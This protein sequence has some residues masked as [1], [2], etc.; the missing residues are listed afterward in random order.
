M[1]AHQRRQRIVFWRGSFPVI[2][3][4]VALVLALMLADRVAPVTPQE[5]DSENLT[6]PEAHSPELGH[7]AAAQILTVSQ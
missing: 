4:F 1:N 5:L 7:K 3:G 2:L 6:Q